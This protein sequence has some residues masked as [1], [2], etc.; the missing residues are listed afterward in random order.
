MRRKKILVAL[1]VGAAVLS[2]AVAGSA[3]V[4]FPSAC[5]PVEVCQPVTAVPVPVCQPVKA[6]PACGPV[7]ACAPVAVRGGHFAARGHR[8]VLRH[9]HRL[10]AHYGRHHCLV[11]QETAVGSKS[12]KLSEQPTPAPAPLP[13][14]PPVSSG[15]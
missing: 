2:R 14:A 3:G 5:K 13:P 8:P 15:T 7:Q 12:L 10:G 9:K 6:V 1:A 4:S 11:Y